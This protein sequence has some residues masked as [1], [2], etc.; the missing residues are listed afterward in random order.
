MLNGLSTHPNFSPANLPLKN[1]RFSATHNP[2]AA[3]GVAS[4]G[5]GSRRWSNWALALL[6]LCFPARGLRTVGILSFNC[7]NLGCAPRRCFIF[8]LRG[9]IRSSRGCGAWINLLGNEAC[10]LLIGVQPR[11]KRSVWESL[12][13]VEQLLWVYSLRRAGAMGVAL[14]RRWRNQRLSAGDGA[15]YLGICRVLFFSRGMFS[16][17]GVHCLLANCIQN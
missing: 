7:G 2:G 10:R 9:G 12:R 5:I 14:G 6:L 13:R 17:R 3:A 16:I 4:A 15:M 11:C 1:A 8:T